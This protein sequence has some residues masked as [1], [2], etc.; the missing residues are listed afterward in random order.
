M[1]EPH[2]TLDLPALDG[3]NPLGF[4][5]ALG[6]LTV[7]AETDPTIKLGW[8][9]RTRWV[10]FLKSTTIQDE[11]ALLETLI[12]T[13]HRERDSDGIQYP[14][15]CEIGELK[16]CTPEHFRDLAKSTTRVAEPKQRRVVDMIAAFGIEQ[17]EASQVK[18]NQPIEIQR[19]PFCFTTGSGHQELVADA[20][21][22]M[23]GKNTSKTDPNACP[24]VTKEL[25]RAALFERWRYDDKGL[26]LRWDPSEDTRYAL[27]LE[28]PSN[29]GAYTVW[30]A[31][32]LA[33]RAL[34]LFP[35]AATKRT[36]A[37]TAWNDAQSF[38]WPI[39][40]APLSRAT[41]A[42]LLNHR[43]L[44]CEFTSTSR[45]EMRARG[46]DVVFFARRIQVGSSSQY[47]TNF[48]APSTR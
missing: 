10:P 45:K 35:C 26:S 47:K 25:M 5:A 17:R 9:A 7:L 6:T 14:K 37:T 2:Y 44:S 34:T 23:N 36:I 19:T 12:K 30:M 3:A 32:A 11:D 4:L 1:S 48:A 24:G 40:H 42:S 22:L 20:R 27:R 46:V 28:N 16:K 21:K 8:H 13:F 29:S 33:F 15:E 41:I 43:C 31:N 39:W 38:S 18:T